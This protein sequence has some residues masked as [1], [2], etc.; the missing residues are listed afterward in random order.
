MANKTFGDLPVRSNITTDDF[1]ITNRDK[2]DPSPE[3]R[4]SFDILKKTIHNGLIVKNAVYNT[5]KKVNVTIKNNNLDIRTDKNEL[6]TFK[7]DSKNVYGILQISCNR[8]GN[9]P[10]EN[11]VVCL[12]D[13]VWKPAAKNKLNV[14][15]FENQNLVISNNPS[16]VTNNTCLFIPPFI[17]TSSGN[18]TLSVRFTQTIQSSCQI[19]SDLWL[20]ETQ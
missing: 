12:F 5:D 17:P 16:S 8:N 6:I 15:I 13:L 20:L 11:S 1:F 3:G 19:N 7:D 14:T 4:I 18:F 10:I 9:T 2:Q